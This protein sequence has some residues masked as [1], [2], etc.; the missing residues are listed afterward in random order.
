MRIVSAIS[1]RLDLKE[2]RVIVNLDKYGNTSTASIPIALQEAIENNK[3]TIPSTM[4]LCG[5]GAGLT[6]DSLL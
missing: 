1:E 5:F 4:A 6:W 2:N 3:V